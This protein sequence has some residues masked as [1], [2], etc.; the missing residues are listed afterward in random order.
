MKVYKTPNH[1]I[2]TVETELPKLSCKGECKKIW[3]ENDIH[4][5]TSLLTLRSCPLCGGKMNIA[6]EFDYLVV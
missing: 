1:L 6:I 5:G 4:I 3:W 2:M